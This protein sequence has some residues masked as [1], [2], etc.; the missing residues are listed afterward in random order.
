MIAVLVGHCENDPGAESE[1]VGKAEYAYNRSLALY[2]KAEW[3]AMDFKHGRIIISDAQ[4][5]G[6]SILERI[7]IA[8]NMGVDCAVELHHNVYVDERDYS[9]TFTQKNNQ[10]SRDLAGGLKEAL[11][12]FV[13]THGIKRWVNVPLPS[14]K[15]PK[16][17]AVQSAPYPATLYEPF[18]MTDIDQIGYFG[19]I[20]AQKEHG[21][22]LAHYL[23]HFW[24]KYY[25]SVER[26][27][28]GQ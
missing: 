6:A 24:R 11:W 15:W 13:G 28:R 23:A 22:L 2:I 1:V 3:E 9:L 10:I 27:A 5:S 8:K 26:Q 25:G 19:N 12:D 21:R 4:T 7:R 18:S 16:K 20:P 14:P 17:A